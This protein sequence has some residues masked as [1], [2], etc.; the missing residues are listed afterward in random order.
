MNLK[1][2]TA[3]RL[4]ISLA[5]FGEVGPAQHAGVGPQGIDDAGGRAN[6]DC[7]AIYKRCIEDLPGDGVVPEQDAV[8]GT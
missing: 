4:P 5:D 2:Y 3:V 1:V 6:V 7:V 8:G